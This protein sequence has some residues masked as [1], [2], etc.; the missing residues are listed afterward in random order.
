MDA[1]NIAALAIA[2]D[3]WVQ[4]R[5]KSAPSNNSMNKTNPIVPQ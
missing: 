2:R 5:P 1:R 3:L 4:T